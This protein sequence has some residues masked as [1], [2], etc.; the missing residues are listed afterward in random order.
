[1]LPES[2]KI[3]A[4]AKTY[5]AQKTPCALITVV[6]TRGS[7]PRLAQTCMLVTGTETVGTVGGGHLEFDAVKQARSKLHPDFETFETRYPLGA[8]LGQCCGGEVV[9]RTEQL[10]A[11]H[12]Q[13]MRQLFQDTA[14]PVLLFGAGH[15][16]QALVR[17]LM[18]LPVR[19][20]WIAVRDTENET[21]PAI[22]SSLLAQMPA[23]FQYTVT[24]TPEAELN[25]SAAQQARTA[26]VIMTHQHSLDERIVA[27]ALQQNSGVAWRYLGLI[28][29]QTKRKKFEQRLQAQNFKNFE[30]LVCP[31]G[32]EG[33]LDK[34][35]E[36]VAISVAASLMTLL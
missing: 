14:L 23:H 15:V 31:I 7:V 22:P 5:L 26:V 25:L 1:M 33:I 36:V 20:T 2:L 3:A 9:L 21:Q 27:T 19:L 32:V 35:P 16:A 11:Q 8:K 17:V 24:D 28:G 6:R 4:R 34:S 18:S 30:N 12:T 10:A 29:S 13:Y